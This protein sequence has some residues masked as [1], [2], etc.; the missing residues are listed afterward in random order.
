MMNPHILG[1]TLILANVVYA[2]VAGPTVYVKN[3]EDKF[4]PDLL[5]VSSTVIPLSIYKVGYEV[6]VTS[7]TKHDKLDTPAKLIT[8]NSKKK[9]QQEKTQAKI[10]QVSKAEFEKQKS[11]T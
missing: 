3:E 4:Q 5:P 9:Y 8:V 7:D 2:V 6:S 11:E 10:K 1:V